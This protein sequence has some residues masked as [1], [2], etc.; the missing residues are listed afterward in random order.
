[1]IGLAKTVPTDVAN[2]KKRFRIALAVAGLTATAWAEQNQVDPTYLSRFLGGKTTS[3]P[4]GEKIE[5][6]IARQTRKLGRV[7]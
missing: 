4:L 5:L 7:S 1:M 6:F 2:R 3:A